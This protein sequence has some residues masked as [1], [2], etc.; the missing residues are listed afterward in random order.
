MPKVSVLLPVYNCEDYIKETIDSVLTQTF[1]D[2]ELIIIDDC[3][4]DNT[5]EIIEKYDDSRIKFIRKEKN[6]GY[7]DSLNFGIGV[8]NGEYIARLDG[9]DICAETRFEKQVNFLDSNPEIILCGTAIQI[10]GT[11]DILKHPRTHEEIKIK[12]C[13]GT[14][15]CHPSVMVR[16]KVL[17]E[18][19]YDKNFEPAED[20]ELWTRLAFKG[21]LANIDEVLLFYR[22]H[23]NQVSNTKK[24]I[25]H[26][27]A[28]A[29]RKRM[30][31][32][33]DLENHFSEQEINHIV[34]NAVPNTI[35][36]CKLGID[37]FKFL[38]SS[39]KTHKIY[40]VELFNERINSFQ[41]SFLRKYFTKQ[42][43]FKISSIQ[44]FLST[45]TINDFFR[46]SKNMLK[47]INSKNDKNTI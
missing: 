11:N 9:D 35:Q 17:E 24:E 47:S 31:N 45:L 42:N 44:F 6:S 25:Q 36:D 13:F 10:I 1:P 23:S 16:K 3:S 30:L 22:I 7:T 28:S 32:K 14:A 4:T 43:F 19:K 21:R 38:K 37:L 2:F 26:N 33:L 15:F 5:V 46:I 12:L 27:A 18:N 40:D 20:Y 29:C 39:N 8:A 41:T 34:I